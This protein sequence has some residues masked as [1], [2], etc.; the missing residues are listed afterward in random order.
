MLKTLIL[1]LMTA[2]V[3]WGIH[4]WLYRLQERI[5]GSEAY[6]SAVAPSLEEKLL[7]A[8]IYG[9]RGENHEWI[10]TT[11]EPLKSRRTTGKPNAY[12]ELID[13]AG[14]RTELEEILDAADRKANNRRS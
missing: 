6:K 13:D 5:Q 14:L 2:E 1:M 4:G 12:L 11:G 8:A 3:Q 7:H 9:E 10:T